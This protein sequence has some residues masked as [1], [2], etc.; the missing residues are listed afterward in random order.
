MTLPNESVDLRMFELAEEYVRQSDPGFEIVGNYMSP[1]S[2]AYQKAS[3]APA[4]DRIQSRFIIGL[5]YKIKE[6]VELSLT[7]LHSV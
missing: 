4:D 3:L 5:R 2:D 1:C 6:R 7:A